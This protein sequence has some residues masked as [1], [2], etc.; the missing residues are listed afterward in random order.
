MKARVSIFLFFSTILFQAQAQYVD[1]GRMLID[2]LSSEAFAGRAYV[3]G[4]DS[5]A[6]EF[7]QRQCLQY[8]SKVY[9]QTFE[10]SAYSLTGE[11]LV[12][13]NNHRFRPGA[14]YL[15]K[16]D[17]KTV[18]DSL[19]IL[20][21]DSLTRYTT[22]TDLETTFS[23][24]SNYALVIDTFGMIDKT[25]FENLQE[26]EAAESFGAV[27]ELTHKL[28]PYVPAAEPSKSS[29]LY[30]LESE[31]CHLSDTLIV[32]TEALY[33]PQHRSQNIMAHLP[34]KSDT[35][36]VFSAH[37]DHVGIMG[38]STY[39]PG[40]NDNASGVAAVLNLLRYFSNTEREYSYYFLFFSGEESGL[41][42]SVH[43][44]RN[45]LFPLSEIKFL[46]NLDMVGSGDKGIQVVNGSVHRP[47][48]NKMREINEE[49]G[50]LP[51]IKIRGA[52]ANSDH[53]PFHAMGVPAFFIYT[54]GDYK[55]YHNI[56][57][58]SEALPLT[59]FDSL[60]ELLILFTQDF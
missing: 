52:A 41:L 14:D 36:I 11:N 8:T 3:S 55:E 57:D 40:A 56:Y 31:A 4:G 10:L 43:Y 12:Q 37:Y 34:G 29:Y 53:Y 50:L 1:Y 24:P 2:S 47:A 33:Q 26:E 28:P 20:K 17:S 42:G 45:P 48:F 7:I 59:A 19:L 58:R 25:I 32:Q 23:P 22:L 54:L 13:T 9:I 30:L 39:F 46:I 27:V 51:E 35:A 18:D 15:F 6:A 44:I 16:S 49:N 60:I 38:D 21:I 5:I